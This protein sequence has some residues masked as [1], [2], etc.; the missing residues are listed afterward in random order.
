M[1]LR[2]GSVQPTPPIESTIAIYPATLH[3]SD[4]LA[5]VLTQAFHPPE[6]VQRFFF[7]LLKLS[8]AK[9]IEQRLKSPAPQYC[10]L[11]AWAREGIVGT[12][13]VSVRR[14]GRHQQPYLSNLAVLPR[15]RR[16]GIARQLLLGAEG[17]V[18][19]WGYAKLHLHVVEENHPARRLYEG[20]GYRVLQTAPDPLTWFGFPQQ[21]LLCKTLRRA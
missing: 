13:E 2:E 17:V 8:I 1:E 5:E 3:Q 9:D 18:Q 20:I 7:P 19:V 15:W 11:A 6:G 12:V 10:C 16:Q 14:V 4:D 21:L